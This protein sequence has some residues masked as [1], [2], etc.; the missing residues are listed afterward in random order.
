MPDYPVVTDSQNYQSIAAGQT[1]AALG[2]GGGA[3]GD[4]LAGLLLVP[5][6]TSPGAVSIA[7]GGGPAITVFAGGAASL[8]ALA[9]FFV[10]VGAFSTSGK[11]QVTTGAGVSALAVGLFT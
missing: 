7:D 8:V 6:S 10:P 4:Y 1:A 5:A 2:A 9:P 11:W 3:R